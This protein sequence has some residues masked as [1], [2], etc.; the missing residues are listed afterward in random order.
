MTVRAKRKER[1]EEPVEPEHR[2]RFHSLLYFSS[3]VL[4]KRYVEKEFAVHVLGKLGR[5]IERVEA[6]VEDDVV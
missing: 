1:A 4:A 5:L 3:I 6:V 2:I